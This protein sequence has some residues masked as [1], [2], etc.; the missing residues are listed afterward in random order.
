MKKRILHLALKDVYFR[1]IQSGKKLFEYRLITDYWRKRIENR[2]YDEIHITLGYPKK[3][4]NTRRIVR[5]WRGYE[6]KTITHEHFDNTP[7]EV[8]ALRVN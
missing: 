3:G 1:Q 2:E 5:P 7:S 8:F 4:D 6:V